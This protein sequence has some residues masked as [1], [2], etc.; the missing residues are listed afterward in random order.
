MSGRRRYYKGRPSK[1]LSSIPDGPC[2]YIWTRYDTERQVYVAQFPDLVNVASAEGASI[3]EA[4]IAVQANFNAM[5]YVR[6]RIPKQ[7]AYTS[8]KDAPEFAGGSWS[9]FYPKLT[10]IRLGDIDH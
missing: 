7:R 3:T 5:K 10:S 4:C 9:S 2:Y 1:G 6:P 8:M